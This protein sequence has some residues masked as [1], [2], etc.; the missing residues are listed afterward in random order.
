MS[1]FPNREDG[2]PSKAFV[3][4]TWRGTAA[5]PESPKDVIGIS[6]NCEDG[7]VVR[8]LMTHECARQV[9]ATL[10]TQVTLFDYFTSI[11]S[12]RLQEAA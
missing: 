10:Q 9:A 6:F 2:P 5:N 1:K 3:P 7:N 11:Q 8:L 4:V 12:A